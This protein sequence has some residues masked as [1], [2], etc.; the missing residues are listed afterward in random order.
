[1]GVSEYGKVGTVVSSPFLKQEQLRF[2]HAG[3]QTRA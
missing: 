1:M 3:K 2:G